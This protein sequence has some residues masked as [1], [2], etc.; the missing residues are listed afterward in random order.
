MGEKTELQGNKY[1]EKVPLMIRHAKR[2]E[3]LDMGL[4]RER[5]LSNPAVL[6]DILDHVIAI[7]WHDCNTNYFIH[8]QESNSDNIMFVTLLGGGILEI[9][10]I[11]YKITANS[12]TVIPNNVDV[13]YYT[14]IREGDWE[15]YWMHVRGV[16]VSNILR[17][18]YQNNIYVIPLNT[19]DKYAAIFE[20]ILT[21]SCDGNEMVLYNSRKISE[22]LHLF[23]EETIAKGIILADN[24]D[25]VKIVLQYIEKNYMHQINLEDISNRVFM[26]VEHT[27]R[28]FKKYTGYTPHSYL[29]MYR[30][31]RACDL[32]SNTDMS[33]KEIAGK[34]GYKSDSN[35]ISE[36]KSLKDMTPNQ[37]RKVTK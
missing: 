27:I 26:S 30:M 13:R 3:I 36:F 10:G 16:N 7:G 25:F 15:F 20:N 28:N 37:F 4:T 22:L 32:L 5:R 35:F 8:H 11:T 12:M 29:K 34:V 6:T 14:D 9:G 18:L 21:L 1:I 17:R 31:M 33:V 24:N 19:M 23:V 2:N